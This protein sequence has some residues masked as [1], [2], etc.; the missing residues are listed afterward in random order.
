MPL[1]HEKAAFA[2]AA[3]KQDVV[4]AAARAAAA[5]GAVLVFASS[6]RRAEGMAAAMHAAGISALHHHA[7]L[8]ATQH[9]A[10]EQL[11]RSGAVRVLVATPTRA[12][13]V[14]P[15]CR[16]VILANDSHWNGDGW[17]PLPVWRYLQMS[18]RAER[19]GDDGDG[20]AMLVAPR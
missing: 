4:I 16:T 9:F 20:K 19:P 11:F 18:G 3:Q 1:A 5:E 7:G 6:R 17:E 2:K 14:S 12:C 8:T 13:G 15:P 10:V